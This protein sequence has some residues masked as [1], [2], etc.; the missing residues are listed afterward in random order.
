MNTQNGSVFDKDGN[1]LTD[2]DGNFINPEDVVKFPNEHLY[3]FRGRHY[4][5]SVYD[6]DG[7]SIRESTSTFGTLGWGRQKSQEADSDLEKTG[8]IVLGILIAITIGLLI[9]L[10]RHIRNNW[11]L[12][13][14]S[15]QTGLVSGAIAIFIC[16]V[17]MVE[18]FSKRDMIEK[19]ITLG[20]FVLLATSVVAGFV[21]SRTASSLFGKNKLVQRLASGLLAG[22]FTGT[23]IALLVILGNKVNLRAVFLN[24]SPALYDLLTLKKGIGNLWVLPTVG[25]I[26][27]ML[28]AAYLLLPKL[29]SRP[30]NRGLTFVIFMAL[31]SG[32]FRVVMINQGPGMEDVAKFLFGQS[33]L[34]LSGTIIFFITV[35]AI[36]IFWNNKGR[37]I[38]TSI[39]RLPKNGQLSL[40]VLTFALIA[41]IVLGLPLVSGPFIA[42]VIVTVVLFIL[43]GLGLNITLGFAGLLDLGFV[44]FYAIG[45]YTVGLLTSYGPFGL[46]HVSFY[47]SIPIAMLIAISF[48]PIL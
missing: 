2:K 37:D 3:D 30:I 41:Y 8:F 15:L 26:S 14:L 33:G 21:T 31:F 29:F 16:L 48:V 7:K 45:A 1:P 36:T 22:L 20:Q 44:A 19:T 28:G 11:Q 4:E 24:A 27:G 40:R 39:S 47:V 18:I 23:L 6:S 13:K 9:F 10:Y 17:G 46:Q 25:A 12:Y 34:T 32:L 42:Q 5:G 38:Q 35:V 43:M